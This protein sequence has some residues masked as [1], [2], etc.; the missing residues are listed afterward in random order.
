M[1]ADIADLRARLDE[2]DKRDKEYKEQVVRL[3][4]VLDQATALLTRNSADVGA[5]AAEGRAGHRRAAGPHRGAVPRDRAAEPAVGRRAQSAGDAARGA[6]ADAEQD[7]RQG[8]ADDAG[9][10]GAAVAAGGAAARDRAARR[11]APLL[12][13][14]HPA[15][16]GRTRARRRPTWRS[17]CR[18]CRRASSRTRPPSSRRCS[19]AYPS[20]A[21]GAGGDVAALARVRAASLLHRRAL[22]ARRPGE[23]LPEVAARQRRQERAQGASPSSP[24]PSCTS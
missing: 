3:R 13:R 8:R 7:R 11:R 23:A 21:R 18:S 20:V 15:L 10:Q 2:I 5:K 6:G 19:T 9:R 12:P 22:A 1:R 17:A 24:S 4:K 16:P 14:V